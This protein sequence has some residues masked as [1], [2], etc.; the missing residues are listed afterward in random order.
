[1]FETA[2]WFNLLTGDIY[3]WLNRPQTA[4]S[5]STQTRSIETT[6]F[7]SSL[8]PR[9][10]PCAG[11]AADNLSARRRCHCCCVVILLE[12]SMTSSLSSLPSSSSRPSMAPCF[13]KLSFFFKFAVSPRSSS[14]SA[15]FV[16]VFHFLFYPWFF[17]LLFL[18]E[19]SHLS[20]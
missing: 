5:H 8:D 1:M 18:F 3:G 11:R 17:L 10:E 19:V 6:D 9:L 15:F 4:A 16:L 13:S 12:F 14:S 20:L 2:L 7:W